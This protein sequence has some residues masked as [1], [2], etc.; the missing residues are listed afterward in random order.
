MNNRE[1]SQRVTTESREGALYPFFAVILAS[2]VIFVLTYNFLDPPVSASILLLA[3]PIGIGLTAWREHYRSTG[4]LA[5]SLQTGLFIFVGA[6]VTLGA[7]LALNPS[8][9]M[10]SVG[11]VLTLLLIAPFLL[12]VIQYLNLRRTDPS[13]ARVFLRPILFTLF[14]SAICVAADTLWFRSID[15]LWDYAGFG[16]ISLVLNI[17]ARLLWPGTRRLASG[18]GSNNKL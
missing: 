18:E 1:L 3:I 10:P 13:G 5:I 14:P 7:F 16:V 4:S 2:L 6:S 15:G 12:L 8:R 17:A 9:G 11:A